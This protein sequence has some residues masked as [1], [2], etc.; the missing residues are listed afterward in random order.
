MVVISFLGDILGKA[1]TFIFNI[2]GDYG[3]SII[4]FTFLTKVLLFPLNMVTQK[5]SINMV[6]LMPEENALKIKY[7][8]DKDKLGEEQ[9]KL[10]KKYH[11]HPLLS[12]VPL[13]IQI[14]LVLGLVYVMYHPLT[15]ILQF[16][17]GI[18][19]QFRD[20]LAAFADASKLKENSYQL[21]IVSLI[22]GALIPEGHALP[23]A[24]LASAE[25][26]KELN[27]M[28]F[29][30]DLSKTPSFKHDYILLLIPLLSGVSAWL[31]CVIQNRINVLQVS[32]GNL[33][34]I[35]TTLFMI[36]FS[37]Y[38][39][40]LVPAGVGLYWIFG[41]LFAIPFMYLYNILMP[42]K[43]YIDYE[44]LKKMNEQRIEKEKIHKKYSA[45]EKED[46]KKFFAV[47]DMK[48]MFYS[49]SNGFYK[50]FKGTIDYICEHSDLDIHYVTSDPDDKI[51][52][53]TRPQIHPYYIGSDRRLVPL[54]MK[55]ECDMVVMTM[56][57]L[58]KYHIKRSRVKKD[59]EYVFA[60]HGI[61]SLATF[62]KGALDWFDTI[63]VP[64]VDQFN[65]IRASEDVYNTQK[66][67][68]VETGYPLMDDMLATYNSSEHEPNKVP[69]ILIA[70]SWQ[71]DNIIDL[72]ID[73]LL[74]ELGKTDYEI[75]LRPHPQQVRHE[76]EKFEELKDKFRD[77][78]NITVQTD[79]SSNNPVM[80]SDILI[81][82]WSDIAWEFAFVTKRP[83][84]FIDSPMKVMN[85]EYDKL[86]MEPM[87]LTLRTEVGAVVKPDEL[88]K[89]NGVI[90]DMLA[91]R[92][93]YAEK[94][95]KVYEEHV[96]NIGKSDKLSGRYIIKRLTG[97]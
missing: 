36:A 5:N 72:C 23:D 44:Y 7:I 27:M 31:M 56:P 90:A 21:E 30:I 35:L 75:I 48:L 80:E 43:K 57:D 42:P 84:L 50:Y 15:F 81:T 74:A 94:I 93:E 33:N 25:K 85:N 91:K 41:N 71:A 49:E 95:Q 77:N 8:D 4:I 45:R 58:E 82:D 19:S 54:F 61:G 64:S 32:Q 37:T 40:F 76:P 47:K 92:E 10:Y 34:K 14:P 28:F 20:W 53:D 97:K 1:M 96:Y 69:K 39:A 60:S 65:E 51:F 87:N 11:Y 3:L 88:E 2:V 16:N 9:L 67:R 52:Q 26:I 70:P 55:L 66:K 59:V 46:Y 17:D 18:I 22:K 12:S 38:F 62:R 6:R 73:G 86:G 29:G 13:L 89:A 79:F 24:L 78:G 63:L 83:V 68:L